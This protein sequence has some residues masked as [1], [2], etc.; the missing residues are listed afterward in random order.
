MPRHCGDAFA[1]NSGY[2]IMPTHEQTNKHKLQQT[3]APR[4]PT[5]KED[6][7]GRVPG[8]DHGHKRS[9]KVPPVINSKTI[10]T[11]YPNLYLAKVCPTVTTV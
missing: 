4:P 11:C 9:V 1:G 6:V 2:S 10:S 7:R 5:E 3:H 8:D